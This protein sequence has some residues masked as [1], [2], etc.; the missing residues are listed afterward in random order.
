[1]RSK[2]KQSSPIRAKRQNTVDLEQRNFDFVVLGGVSKRNE[3]RNKRKLEESSDTRRSRRILSV[4]ILFPPLEVGRQKYRTKRPASNTKRAS[5]IFSLFFFS[6]SGVARKALETPLFSPFLP[7]SIM[8]RDENLLAPTL[9]AG[10]ELCPIFDK[11]LKFKEERKG[12][13]FVSI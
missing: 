6:L 10:R 2:R 3:G 1:M 4:G 7:S 5:N 11:C 12:N 9:V 13:R 8:P